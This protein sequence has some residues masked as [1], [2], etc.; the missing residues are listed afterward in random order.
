MSGRSQVSLHE[1]V[2]IRP[3]ISSEYGTPENS[4]TEDNLVN[5]VSPVAATPR[6]AN[7]EPSEGHSA[8]HERAAERDRE[9]TRLQQHQQAIDLERQQRDQ[10]HQQQQQAMMAAA[11]MSPAVPAPI[12]YTRWEGAV[13]GRQWAA[14]HTL[15]VKSIMPWPGADAQATRARENLQVISQSCFNMEDRRA[16]GSTSSSIYPF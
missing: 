13:C 4:D 16:W 6:Q 11:M 7:T 1:R 8:R 10:L 12:P 9:K 2:T 5:L 14:A 15:A 3:A